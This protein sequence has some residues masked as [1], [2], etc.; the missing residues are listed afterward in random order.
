MNAIILN[1]RWTATSQVSI[2]SPGSANSSHYERTPV[3]IF[4]GRTMLE[5][6]AEGINPPLPCLTTM[7]LGTIAVRSGPEYIPRLK[8]LGRRV[9]T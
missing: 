8:F 3:L 6:D 7:L 2:S 4:T 9:P 1:C 5:G